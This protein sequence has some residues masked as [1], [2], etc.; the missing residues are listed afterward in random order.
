MRSYL[1]I[2]VVAFLAG[3]S[4][5]GGTYYISSRSGDDTNDGTA[6]TK[7]WR[8]LTRAEKVDLQGNSLLLA[9]GETFEGRLAIQGHGQSGEQWTHLGSYGNGRAIVLSRKGDGIIMRDVAP[10]SISNLVVQ[11]EGADGCGVVVENTATNAMLNGV[12]LSSLDVTGFGQHGVTISGR[13]YGF[14]KVRVE[15]CSLHGN[16]RGGLEIAGKLGWN[17]SHYAHA[18]VEVRDCAAFDNSG[19]PAFQSSHSGS[20]IVLYQVDGGLVERCAAWNNG[21]LCPATGGGPVGIWT[22]ASRRVTIQFCE[23]FAN[24]TRR[25]DGGGFDIDGGS[26]ECV[27]QCNY[28]HDNFGPGLMVYTY[29]YAPFRDHNNTVR[30]NLSVNDGL[31][32]PEEG[33]YAGLWVRADAGKMSGLKIYNNTVVTRGRNAAYVFGDRVACSIRNNVFLTET[34][35]V[36]LIVEWPQSEVKVSRNVFWSN[37]GPVACQWNGKS[38]KTT[39]E[40]RTARAQ[41]NA[42]DPGFVSNPGLTMPKAPATSPMNNF[43]PLAGFRASVVKTMELAWLPSDANWDLLGKPIRAP[44]GAGA[45]GD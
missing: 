41:V 10:L 30:F 32:G 31:G 23:S 36:P 35:G 37:G 9:G 19:D 5:D 34:N 40:F 14:K 2:L 24:K 39:E 8:T 42:D 7:P 33:R 29:P 45:I 11:G 15:G 38:Y 12:M 27:L 3:P 13:E 25:M 43:L 28:S 6:V 44:I 22:C 17:A 26:E 16:K 4:V 18:D 21:A 1:A 20:G